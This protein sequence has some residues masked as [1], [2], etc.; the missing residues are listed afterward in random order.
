[1]ITAADEALLS[2]AIELAAHAVALGDAPYGSLLAAEH[3]AARLAD[4]ERPVAG[5]AAGRTGSVRAG[6]GADRDLLPALVSCALNS[7]QIFGE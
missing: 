4:P 1:M 3:R 5:R 7:F 2:R 6:A